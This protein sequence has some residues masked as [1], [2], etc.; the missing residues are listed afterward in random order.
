MKWILAAVLATSAS[1]AWT[2][3][4]PPYSG[5][6]YDRSGLTYEAFGALGAGNVIVDTWGLAEGANDGA[7]RSS[8]LGASPRASTTCTDACQLGVPFP[9]SSE[10]YIRCHSFLNTFIPNERFD[11]GFS[12][13]NG[14]DFTDYEFRID[15]NV[16]TPQGCTFD[17]TNK[18][19]YYNQNRG[20]GDCSDARQC[21]CQ[22]S[23]ATF[24]PTGSPVATEESH[25]DIDAGTDNSIPCSVMPT[26]TFGNSDGVPVDL[27]IFNYTK[28]TVDAN[29]VITAGAD[30]TVRPW[31]NWLSDDLFNQD[32]AFPFEAFKDVSGESHV[33]V[34]GWL[35]FVAPPTG[36][37]GG[38]ATPDYPYQRLKDGEDTSCR[39]IM[40]VD[41]RFDNHEILHADGCAF[42]TADNRTDYLHLHTDE[43]VWTNYSFYVASTI[44][45]TVQPVLSCHDSKIFSSGLDRTWQ[46][47]A[48]TMPTEWKA[49]YTEFIQ[50]TTGGAWNSDTHVAQCR[51]QWQAVRLR[52]KYGG[53]VSIADTVTLDVAHVVQQ[54]DG[55]IE[56]PVS[57]EVWQKYDDFAAQQL[58]WTHFQHGTGTGRYHVSDL[59]C[60]AA[61]CSGGVVG[62]ADTTA[63]GDGQQLIEFGS[64]YSW[65]FVVDDTIYFGDKNLQQLV[66]EQYDALNV[67]YMWQRCDEQYAPCPLT[68]QWINLEDY[69]KIDATKVGTD[70]AT[71]VTYATSHTT[72]GDHWNSIDYIVQTPTTSIV[73]PLTINS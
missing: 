13:S 70:G 50:A 3:V 14:T 46:S 35:D 71:G 42:A 18:V 64:H 29:N 32:D 62:L 69:Y 65:Q 39:A 45:Y 52:V 8:Y 67:N 2:D 60:A 34:S 17:P 16:A 41:G 57:E 36:F 47:D 22:C 53:E 6:V 27:A 38:E 72:S 5:E 28:P 56:V 4:T 21:M 37:V 9:D 55:L 68:E 15:T 44:C 49:S 7:G 31:V 54:P 1:A 51:R 59:T 23:F 58:D 25:D 11:T 43:V 73:L 33:V 19:L 10:A 63:A 26:D 40:N 24:S 20:T 30:F 48:Y 61:A 66:L 12:G